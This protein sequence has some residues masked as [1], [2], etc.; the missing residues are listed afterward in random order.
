MAG[1]VSSNGPIIL[2]HRGGAGEA[3]E[4]SLAAYAHAVEVGCDYLELDVWLGSDGQLDIAHGR[5]DPAA[6]RM[7]LADLHARFPDKFLA[8]DP[9][10]DQAVEPLAAFIVEQSL[11]GSVCIG[12][13]FDKRADR[14][15]RLVEAASGS[16]PATA[17]VSA[18][19]SL[20]LLLS[21]AALR[22][23]REKFQA[24]F[25]H[26]HQRLITPRAVRTAHGAGLKLIAWT[27]NDT[28]TMRKFL[29]WG[30]DGFMTDFPG[31]AKSVQ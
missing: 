21:T 24:S 12:A 10:H 11:A 1:Y 30:V 22:K 16:R 14:V 17:L 20:D 26:A 9:K 3:P 5:P 29:D 7:T 31:K 28:A 19:S 25:I 23:R 15:A 18:V 13:S 4:S 8:I 27:V 2:A 6:D